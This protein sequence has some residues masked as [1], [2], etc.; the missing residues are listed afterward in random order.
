[1]TRLFTRA[2][3]AALA[4]L[5]LALAA[6][7]SPTS[8]T[9]ASPSAGTPS[10]SA[11]VDVKTLTVTPGKLTIATGQ[12]AYSP[13][14]ENDKPESGE[15][16][17]AAVA[18]AVAGKLGFTNADVVW[19][20]TTFDQAIAPGAKDWDF[21]LQ[22]F[23]IT[24]ERKKAVDFSTP[25][26]TTTQTVVTYK[27]SKIAAV[28]SVAGLK[29]A[30]LG[31]QIGTTSQAD[32]T[33]LIAP[34]TQPKVFNT[35]EDAVQALKNKQVDG[36]VVDLP[37]ALYMAAAQLDDGVI[38]GQLADNSGGDEFGLVLQRGSKLTA[39]VSAA[40]DAL[41]TDGTLAALEKKWLSES[42]DVPVLQ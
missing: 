11:S 7:S 35:N 3:T 9:S 26:Y 21:N 37:T 4:A 14:V 31:V 25:Y 24:D 38:I 30:L 20:R 17:E 19:K 6:C 28:N 18:Y 39:P 32:V 22:Q 10:A 8:T 41:R 34:T 12:P 36:L 40:V 42:I 1:M 29:D 27:G 16:F 23:S 15:G 2:A 33:N 13:W 5:T